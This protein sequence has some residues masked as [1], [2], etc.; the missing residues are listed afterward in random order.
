[1]IEIAPGLALAP[2]E[3]EIEAV[4]S[5]GAGGQNVNKVATAVQLRFDIRASSLPDKLKDRLLRRMGR[6][7]TD[8]GVLVLKVQ[9]HRTQ[10][11][12][13]AAALDRLVELI[14]SVLPDPKVR[15]PTRPTAAAR[16]ARLDQKTRRSQTKTLRRPPGE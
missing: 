11:Q 15:R 3:V 4:R 2:T 7:V 16:R 5:Q 13:R 9:Q 6:R 8:E 12:N 1:M 14:Q 10:E